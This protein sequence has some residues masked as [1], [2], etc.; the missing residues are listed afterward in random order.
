VDFTVFA[1]KGLRAMLVAG[2]Y[3]PPSLR[4]VSRWTASGRAPGW[5]EQAVRQELGIEKG[6]APDLPERLE[7]IEIVLRAIASV[8]GVDLDRVEQMRA[9][10]HGAPPQ[11]RRG[12]A[13]QT[14]SGKIPGDE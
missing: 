1:A 10:L 2:G 5:V 14:S 7:R 8:S 6:A 12:A 11:R 9:E 13:R 4:T 3:Q